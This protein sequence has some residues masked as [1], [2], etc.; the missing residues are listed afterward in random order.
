MKTML[1]VLLAILAGHTAIAQ[2]LERPSDPIELAS[3]RDAWLRDKHDAIE[4][5]NRQYIE[6]LKASKARY[7]EAGDA[8]AV[9]AIERELD[10]LLPR[11]LTGSVAQPLESAALSANSS[12]GSFPKRQISAQSRKKIVAILEGKIWR[13]DH[14]GEG[15]RWYYFGKDGRFARK[16]KLTEWVWSGMDGCWKIDA[17]GTVIA[18]GMGNTAQISFADDGK[19]SITLNRSGI[20]TVRPLF[21]TDLDYP[22]IGKE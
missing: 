10:K 17:F 14:G 20:L 12:P 11:T 18:T 8:D 2:P 3:M 13:V 15:L 9:A 1:H 4:A 21:A 22:G 7:A 5:L 6:D 16:S 19:P